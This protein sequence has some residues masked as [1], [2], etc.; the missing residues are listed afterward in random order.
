MKKKEKENKTKQR[1]DDKR[2]VIIVR[3]A[4]ML[5]LISK[6]YNSLQPLL[7]FLF[8][9]TVWKVISEYATNHLLKK[10]TSGFL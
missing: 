6:L 10:Y 1:P 5:S 7:T 3:V 2:T 9:M 4:K 8:C